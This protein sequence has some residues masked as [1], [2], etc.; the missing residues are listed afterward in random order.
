MSRRR[1]AV[2]NQAVGSITATTNFTPVNVTSTL[3]TMLQV[4]PTTNISIIEWGYSF[5]VVPTAVVEVGLMTSGTTSATMN[6]A[7]ASGDVVKYDDAGSAASAIALGTTATGYANA[8][9]PTETAFTGGRVL[10]FQEQWGQSYSKQFP[11]DRE[12]GVQANDFLRI[13]AASATSIGMVCYIVWE[14]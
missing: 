4:K 11:L 8:T 1:Y 5:S 3:H 7:T 14:E 12:P 13:R 9:G 2:W 10:D 6:V